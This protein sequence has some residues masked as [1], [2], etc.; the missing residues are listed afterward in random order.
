MRWTYVP[1]SV[2]FL[3]TLLTSGCARIVANVAADTLSGSGT[4]FSAEDDP[5]LVRQAVP[6]G[7][8]TVESLLTESP[9]NPKLLLAAASGFAQYSYA[10][11]QQDAAEMEPID[12]PR[13]RQMYARAKRLYARAEEY[14]FRGLEASCPGFRA[15]F[16]KDKRQAVKLLEAEQVPLL[17]WTGMALAARIS[18]SKDDMAAIGRLPEVEALM[19]RALELNEAYDSGAIHEF[20][21]SYDAGRSESS[22]GSLQR[23]QEHYDRALVLSGNQKIAPLVNWAELVAVQAQDRELFNKLLAQATEFD[24]YAQPKFRLVNLLAQRRARFLMSQASELFLEE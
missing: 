18:L 11:V 3:L 21:V 24:A 12:S 19:G 16:V 8:K 7:L 4:V 14:G 15:F 23:A 17:Y 22:G 6:F 2:F 13:A 9:D 20:Y 5:E 1:L 10:F